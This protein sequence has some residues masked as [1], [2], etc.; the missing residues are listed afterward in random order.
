MRATRSEVAFEADAAGAAEHRG[1]MAMGP[2]AHD[3][4][5]AVEAG[6]GPPA[7]EQDLEA[8]DEVGGPLGEV[9]QGALFD[10]ARF[11]VGLAQEDGGRGV[12][13]GD[14][15]DVHGYSMHD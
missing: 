11:T 2:G 6:D 7:A 12:A 14:S 4:E 5:G 10:L 8:V 9:G 15:L 3:V 13:V 1:D